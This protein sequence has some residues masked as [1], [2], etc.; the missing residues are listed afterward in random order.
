MGNILHLEM[1]TCSIHLEG[2]EGHSS[3]FAKSCP[4]PRIRLPILK[5]LPQF[6]LTKYIASLLSFLFYVSIVFSMSAW[7][8]TWW[9]SSWGT[10]G[11]YH[12]KQ[13]CRFLKM[14]LN[15]IVCQ[16]S[17]WVA[18]HGMQE[19]CTVNK[20]LNSCSLLHSF[21][22]LCNCYMTDPSWIA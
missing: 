6:L 5:R 18:C 13:V 15:Q 2:G 17:W 4:H 9:Q 11:W 1:H 12:L 16:S 8:E 21:L 14:P 10:K 20:R 3:S 22:L 19:T 7:L